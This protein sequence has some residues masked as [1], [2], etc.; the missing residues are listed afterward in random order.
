MTPEALH[1]M[2][3]LEDHHWWYVGLRDLVRRLLTSPLAGLPPGAHVLDAGCG[4]GANLRLLED[5]LRPAYLGGFDVAEAAVARARARCPAADVYVS[6][7]CNPQVRGAPLDLVTSF[8]VLGITTW[9]AAATGLRALTRHLAPG[10]RLLLHLPAGRRPLGD[11]DC[12]VGNRDRFIMSRVCKA[13]RAWGLDLLLASYRMSLLWPA[14]VARRVWQAAAR[15]AFVDTAPPRSDLGATPRWMEPWLTRTL[16]WESA[17]ICRGV[18][19]LWG[20]SLI[21]LARRPLECPAT[22]SCVSRGLSRR[23]AWAPLG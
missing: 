7:I 22:T 8:D 14:V 12:A 19:P 23:R 1:E 4:T 17:A 5:L 11:H 15:R 20:L 16:A 9:S 10:G 6:D 18:R 13:V 2:D 3:R 21:V